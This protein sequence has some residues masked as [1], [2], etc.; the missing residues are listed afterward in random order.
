MIQDKARVAKLVALAA[1][2]LVA[3]EKQASAYTDPGT[4]ALIWQ[5]FMAVILGAGYL[6][7]KVV[8]LRHRNKEN[9]ES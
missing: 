9:I 1:V 2:L 3:G 6:L 5:S 8:G 7:R 4:G